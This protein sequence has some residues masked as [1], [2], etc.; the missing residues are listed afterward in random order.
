GD[1]RDKRVV[2]GAGTLALISVLRI[3]RGNGRVIDRHLYQGHVARRG[4]TSEI[5]LEELV[6]QNA[7]PTIPRSPAVP[8]TDAVERG[9]IA[10]A[11]Q[12]AQPL[13]L[14]SS[15]SVVR[16]RWKSQLAPRGEHPRLPAAGQ[17]LDV[18][19]WRRRDARGD[20]GAKGGEREYRDGRR[21]VLDRH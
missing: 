13:Q 11:R 9:R 16:R 8:E 14:R 21:T 4:R 15:G 5:V 20:A 19:R 10:L 2:G 18:T 17:G 12:R 7:V 1:G 6:G 3:P